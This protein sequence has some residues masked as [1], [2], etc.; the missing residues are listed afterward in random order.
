MTQYTIGDT[1]PWHGEVTPKGKAQRAAAQTRLRSVISYLSFR[2]AQ[3]E[4]PVT[5]PCFYCG[6]ARTC[7]H[8]TLDEAP[9]IPEM[10]RDGRRRENREAAKPSQ[11]K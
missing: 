2:P 9:P 3:G 8:R 7:D 10:K 1:I 11:W 4:K 6:C 5:A